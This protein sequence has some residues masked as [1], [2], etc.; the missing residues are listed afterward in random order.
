M[1]DEDAQMVLKMG[2]GE[3]MLYDTSET[4]VSMFLRQAALTPD[5]IAIVDKYTSITYHE[6]DCQSDILA[7]SLVD[8]GVTND[9]AVALLFPRRKEFLIAVLAVFKAGGAYVSLDSDYP[10]SRLDFMLNDLN[11]RYLIT[12]SELVKTV[13]TD[14]FTEGGGL[15]LLDHFDFSV[16]ASPVNNSRPES[17]AYI[18]YTSGTSGV[19]KG[20]MVEHR[21]L[22]SMLEW[23]VPME[24]LK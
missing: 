8:A 7:S 21:A 13:S 11:A 24:G 9:S 6:L 10:A 2:R 22:R 1:P 15:F 18:I 19:P 20:V 3:E 23:V 14:K 16:N 12:T 5:A 4:F 17:L